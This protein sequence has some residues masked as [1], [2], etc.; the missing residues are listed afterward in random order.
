MLWRHVICTK[1][2]FVEKF[3]GLAL[4]P[5]PYG[6]NYPFSPTA[7]QNPVAADNFTKAFFKTVDFRR[8]AICT[9][10]FFVEKFFGLA[11]HTY[12]Y[13]SNFTFSPT[14]KQNPPAAVLFLFSTKRKSSKEKA[15]WGLCPLFGVQVCTAQDFYQRISF[16]ICLY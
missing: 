10:E 5:N 11:L 14:A 13:S 9:K 15:I 3:F 6:S 12:P 2:F 16:R 8:H 7:L 4:H 1:E